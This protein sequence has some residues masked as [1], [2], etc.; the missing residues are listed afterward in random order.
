V[1]FEGIRVFHHVEPI[2]RLAGACR[3]ELRTGKRDASL[4]PSRAYGLHFNIPLDFSC[5]VLRFDV[6]ALVVLRHRLAD[7]FRDPSI[8]RTALALV[9]LLPTISSRACLRRSSLVP[10]LAL[11]LP[12]TPPTQA[13]FVGWSPLK[14]TQDIPAKHSE[15]SVGKTDI[16]GNRPKF[17]SAKEHVSSVGLNRSRQTFPLK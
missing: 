13:A 6:V 4:A 14:T 10:V 9:L 7:W 8:N 1:L 16:L 17:F 15:I 11:A 2:Q 3:L 5:T 12:C